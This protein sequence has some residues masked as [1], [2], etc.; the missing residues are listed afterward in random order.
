MEF[1]VEGSQVLAERR[2]IE[3]LF[4]DIDKLQFAQAVPAFQS[5]HFGRAEVAGAIEVQRQ[6]FVHR[7][8]SLRLFCQ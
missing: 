6:R 4:C 8:H 3:T 1:P 2:G 7:D 5:P